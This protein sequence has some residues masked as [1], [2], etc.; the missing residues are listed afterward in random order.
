MKFQR[1]PLVQALG[2]CMV[3]T[4]A[5]CGGGGASS[6][7]A[8]VTATFPSAS[9]A[10]TV[11]ASSPAP[12]LTPA[13]NTAVPPPQPVTLTGLVAGNLAIRNAV[14]CMDLNANNACDADEPASARTGPDG[15][16]SL[17]YDPA[18]VTAAQVAAASLI[19]PMV[20]GALTDPATTV[21]NNNPAAGN[22]KA[23]YVLKQVPGKSG[24]INPLTTLL[25]KGVADGMAE[26]DARANVALQLKIAAEKIDNYQDDPASNDAAIQ[27]NARWMALAVSSAL[28][29]SA[30][31]RVGDQLAAVTPAAGD[32]ASLRFTDANNYF[33][34]AFS[35]IAKA[36]G[37]PGLP[38]L[39]LRTGRTGGSIPAAST[40]YNFA[41]LTP[42]GWT[43][44]DGPWESTSGTPS[45]SVYCGAS[46]SVGYTVPVAIDGRAMADVVTELQADTA[47]NV[48]NNGLSVSTL[49]SSL[50]AALFPAG[51][52]I[53]GRHTMVVAPSIFINSISG[54]GRPQGE[55]QSL[56]DLIRA[57]SVTNV[58]LPNPGGSLSLGQ[59]SGALRNLRA[60][61]IG[62]TSSSAG[63]VQYYECDLDSNLSNPSNC[64]E[65]GTGTYAISTVNEVRVM[66]FAGHQPTVM[67]HERVYVEVQNT[68]TIAVGN[69]VYQARES[70]MD[71]ASAFSVQKRLNNTAWGAIQAVLGLY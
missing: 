55:S 62:M 52:K 30:S 24:Q 38:L 15:A 32:M 56:E 57:K 53:D 20:P 67:N 23:P 44:C 16:Y 13:P 40:E 42:Q 21:D 28:E 63:T 35:S 14:V 69:W 3:L 61:I 26:A 64:A 50:G 39:D 27:D 31:L 37:A 45:R 22:T 54:D 10:T 17:T 18:K 1:Q 12:A 68:P 41:Y 11:T 59:G 34:R 48:I 58:R 7:D 6:P 9:A 5:A 33:V 2:A 46:A 47:T 65:T 36:A 19:A 51:S 43:R 4:V 60:A 70:K 49:L 66:R 71:T 8:S 25:A 29:N